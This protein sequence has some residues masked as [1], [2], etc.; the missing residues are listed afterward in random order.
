[1][2]KLRSTLW[3]ALLIVA[4]T[5]VAFVA[6]A[7]STLDTVKKRGKIL[8][9][10]K[11]D[12]PP[13]AFLDSSQNY[14]GFD[15]DLWRVFAKDL[16]VGLEFVPITSQSRIP[17][18]VNGTIDAVS[19]GTTHTVARDQTIDYSITYFLAGQKLLV[20]KGSGIQSH[21]DLAEP[22]TTA[23]IQ[24]ANSGPNF[25]KAQPRAKLVTFQEYPQAVLA[26]KQSKV[27]AL[28]SDDVLLDQ[29]ARDNPELEVVGPHLTREMYGMLTR[30][31]DSKWRDW[32]NFSIQ[33]AWKKGVYHELHRKHF[34]KDPTYE[35]EI[36]QD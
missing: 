5:C 29:F 20:R 8:L 24:G 22:R 16:G 1:M 3:S 11:A 12:Y 28:T 15:V 31:N 14:V 35:V 32:I 2:M 17:L 26:L 36:W 33:G 21:Q 27:D 10:V 25:I 7:D 30:E 9:G 34:G 19:G 6:L 4:V 23:V 13:F 18:L